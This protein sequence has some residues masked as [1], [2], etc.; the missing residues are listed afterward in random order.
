LSRRRQ[1]SVKSSS[2]S[3]PAK[4]TTVAAPPIAPPCEKLK[5]PQKTS[6]RV[7]YFLSLQ[8][9]H[10]KHHVHHAKHH[11]FTTK[12]PPSNHHFF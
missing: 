10:P 4:S 9:S 12:K 8:N 11:S 3:T 2:E 5:F 6:I 7:A 1:P